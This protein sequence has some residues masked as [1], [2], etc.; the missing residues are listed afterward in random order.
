MPVYEFKRWSGRTET[1]AADEVTFPAGA[2]VFRSRGRIVLAVKPGNW[3]D[4]VDIDA[5]LEDE[6]PQP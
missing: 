6:E 1:V 5:R 2:L 3:D 4:L